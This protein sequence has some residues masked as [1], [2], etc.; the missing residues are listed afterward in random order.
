LKVYGC[1]CFQ[2]VTLNKETPTRSVVRVPHNLKCKDHKVVVW[3]KVPIAD[4]HSMYEL[5][6]CSDSLDG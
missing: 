4:F 3:W 2:C 1:E 5:W 6:K